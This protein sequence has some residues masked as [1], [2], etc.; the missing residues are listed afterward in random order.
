MLAGTRLAGLLGAGR[1]RRQLLPPPGGR[2]PR[3]TACAVA[4]RAAD[5]TVE[6]I[7]GPGFALGVQWHA[8]TLADGRLFEALVGA[9]APAL[10]I[11]A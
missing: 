9:S 2:P 11:A 6:A 10:R 8:E 3:R 7:E 5:G 1:A 4:A